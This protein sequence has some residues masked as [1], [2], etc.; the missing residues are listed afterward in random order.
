MVIDDFIIKKPYTKESEL[1]SYYYDNSE[2]R[3]IKGINTINFLYVD[4]DSNGMQI[5]VAFKSMIK[6]EIYEDYKDNY[7]EKRKSSRTKNEVTRDI[8]GKL[9]IEQKLKISHIVGDSWFASNE[10][11]EHFGDILGQNF[12]FAIKSN[13]SIALK[14]MIKLMGSFIKLKI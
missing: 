6:D 7:K 5:P 8:V 3:I 14:K 13:R 12:L 10:N 9:I 4:K 11:M 2:K 1:N